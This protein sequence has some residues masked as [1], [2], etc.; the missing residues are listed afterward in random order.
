[1]EAV[2]GLQGRWHATEGEWDNS[3]NKL[4]TLCGVSISPN[5]RR[6]N[7]KDAKGVVECPKCREA[8]GGKG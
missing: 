4:K 3:G 6:F 5:Y 1:M 2:K 8:L 7:E